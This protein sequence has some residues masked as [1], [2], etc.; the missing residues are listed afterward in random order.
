MKIF[1]AGA[2]GTLGRPVLHLLL[3]RGHEVVGLTRSERGRRSL[4]QLGARAVVGD[5]LDAEAV[6]SAVMATRPDQIVHLL[7]ALPAGGALRPRQLQ[8]T[9]ELRVAATA[10][11]LAAAI[12]VGARRLVAESFVGVY[13]SG[14]GSGPLSEDDPLPPVTSGPL[15]ATVRA[16]RSLE[17]Q[18]HTARASQ[19]IETVALRIGLL[20]GPDVPSTRALIDQAAAGRLFIPRNLSGIVPFVQIGDAASAI[21]LAIEHPNPSATYNIV[22]DEPIALTA[23][24]AAMTG[25]IGAPPP[26]HV[27]MWLVKLAAPVI[28]E[29]GSA[30]LLLSNAKARRELGWSLRF[31]RVPEG[32]ADLPHRPL[33]AA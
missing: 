18:L 5:A 33:E 21:V 25:V 19:L 3:S 29:G 23:F 28:A 1:V 20:Y 24:L 27:P 32:L 26:R 10:N 17:N 8:P 22:D 13:G 11:L 16:L 14:S 9:N 12:A 2:T 7:T 30:R 6:R 31:P 4:Q 15:A